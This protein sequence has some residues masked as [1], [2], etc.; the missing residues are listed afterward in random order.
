MKNSLTV[1]K[2]ALRVGKKVIVSFPNFGHWHVRSSYIFSGRAPKSKALP[3]EWYNTPNIRVLTI[4]DF[5]VLCK[6]NKITV[7][8]EIDYIED[9]GKGSVV[10]FWPNILATNSLFVLEKN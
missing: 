7:L 4:K 1:L 8:K 5:R 3:Y 6:E 2:E 10:K 9:N